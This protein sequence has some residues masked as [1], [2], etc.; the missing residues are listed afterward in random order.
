ML[1]E[2]RKADYASYT[3]AGPTG[4]RDVKAIIGLPAGTDGL[5]NRLG[6]RIAFAGTLRK[7]E[8]FARKVVLTD[9]QL[10]N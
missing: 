2:A 4:I 10:F 9:A 1:D 7:V 5:E 8:G 6:Q 3:Q